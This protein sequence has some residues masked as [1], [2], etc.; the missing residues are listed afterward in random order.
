MSTIRCVYHSSQAASAAGTATD[1]H[2][3]AVRYTVGPYIVDAIGWEPTLQ[4]VEA[5]VNPPPLSPSQVIDQHFPQSGT[6]RVLFEALFELAND[7][8]ELRRE[9]N[10]ISPG[11]F[12]NANSVD[13]TRSQLKTW[14]ESKL[15]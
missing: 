11:R 12:N 4:E 7:I 3:D 9:I 13:I 2:P 14:L 8:R 5:L 1:Q 10:L 6:A 15:P